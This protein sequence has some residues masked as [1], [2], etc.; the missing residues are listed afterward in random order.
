[1]N[2][3]SFS[4]KTILPAAALLMNILVSEGAYA[5]AVEK[6][7]MKVQ[8]QHQGN[9]LVLSISG[10]SRGW[11]LA[12]FNTHDGLQNARLFFATI[13]KGRT[14]VEEHRTDLNQPAPFHKLLSAQSKKIRILSS[15]KRGQVQTIVM[16][17]PLN[18]VYT[19]QAKLIRGENVNLILAYSNSH[20]FYH[21]SAQRTST[22]IQL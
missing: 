12:G 17:V 18:P 6:I 2:S 7:G 19:D 8:W 16:E 3:R 21:H 5:G 1:M 20:D 22:W 10:P 9:R 14:R 11:V 15:N 4:I 13:E